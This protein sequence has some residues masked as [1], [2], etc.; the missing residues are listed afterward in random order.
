M[1]RHL[2]PIPLSMQF[3]FKSFNLFMT[4]FEPHLCLPLLRLERLY[5]RPMLIVRY[6]Q[7]LNLLCLLPAL[8]LQLLYLLSEPLIPC[9]LLPH[10]SLPGRH[11][12]L[13]LLAVPLPHLSLTLQLREQS[14]YSDGVLANRG[15]YW[16]QLIRYLLALLNKVYDTKTL[17]LLVDCVT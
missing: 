14:E 4:L 5:Q 6:L 2:H 3:P 13:P 7:R 16:H 11:P 15:I 17:H 9:L 1:R 8:Y 10:Q 12:L